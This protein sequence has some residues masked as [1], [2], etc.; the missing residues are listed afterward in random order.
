MQSIQ[1]MSSIYKGAYASI[2][3]L[4]GS[5]MDAVLARIRKSMKPAQ[6]QLLS[7]VNVERIVGLMPTLSQQIHNGV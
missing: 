3:A 6:L 1:R 5:S 4:R 7:P 2:V